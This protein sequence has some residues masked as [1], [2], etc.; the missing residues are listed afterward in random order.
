MTHCTLSASETTTGDREFTITNNGSTITE[1]Y[2][3]TEEGMVLRG[4]KPQ[5]RRDALGPRDDQRS[6]AITQAPANRAWS[7]TASPPR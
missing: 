2:V 4:G 7:A 1:F 5:A 3:V 6:R